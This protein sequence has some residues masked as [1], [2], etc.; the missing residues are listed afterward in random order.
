MYEPL[1]YKLICFND[2]IYQQFSDIL[3][4]KTKQE[5]IQLQ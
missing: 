4:K 1:I 3:S 2:I 5:N